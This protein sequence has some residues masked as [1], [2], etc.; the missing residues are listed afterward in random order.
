MP[1]QV[2][3]TRQAP[4]RVCERIIPLV[5]DVLHN[6]RDPVLREEATTLRNSLSAA[7]RELDKWVVTYST[8]GTWAGHDYQGL[9]KLHNEIITGDQE[10]AD[11]LM[12]TVSECV[13]YC[14]EQL[15][16]SIQ[17]QT[18]QFCVPNKKHTAA[19]RVLQDGF[20]REDLTKLAR[21]RDHLHVLLAANR[22][23]KRWMDPNQTAKRKHVDAA[24][25]KPKLDAQS[26]RSPY[27]FLSQPAQVIEIDDSDDSL[28]GTETA[29]RSFQSATQSASLN[30]FDRQ[31]QGGKHVNRDRVLPFDPE[32]AAHAASSILRAVGR[33][34][35]LPP[36][37]ASLEGVL[38]QKLNKRD[39]PVGESLATVQ[40]SMVKSAQRWWA[41]KD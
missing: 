40:D 31:V 38:P 41:E 1:G 14:E 34:P 10:I 20:L 17:K 7:A 35:D 29:S 19:E 27:S 28:P 21:T 4:P 25:L 24:R 13:E 30:Y 11:C 16:L 26:E 2:I 9:A 5:L 37:N 15:H 23:H 36:L 12:E 6:C 22:K 3:D 39:V 18:E 33:H 32:L 8:Y